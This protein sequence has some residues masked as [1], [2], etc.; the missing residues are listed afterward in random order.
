MFHLQLNIHI[1]INN[2]IYLTDSY[3]QFLLATRA[4]STAVCVTGTAPNL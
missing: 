2:I 4:F 3:Q 1:N